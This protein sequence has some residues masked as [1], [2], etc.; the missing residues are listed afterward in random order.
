MDTAFKRRWS[1]DYIGINEKADHTVRKVTLGKGQYEKEVSWDC[2]RRAVNEKL[3]KEYKVNEDKLIGPF[4]LAQKVIETAGDGSGRIADR[5]AFIKAF[6]N[7]VIM[8]LY[9]DA[10]KQHRQHLFSGCGSSRYS[11]VCDAFDEKGIAV[12]GEN[13]A[14]EYYETVTK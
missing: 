12:F 8:Y 7:K 2:L 14:A 13:F 11:A 3:A 6:K 10:A 5:D 4:F 9:E 1:F